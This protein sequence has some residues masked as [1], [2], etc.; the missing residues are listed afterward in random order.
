MQE[1]FDDPH[2]KAPLGSLDGVAQSIGDLCCAKE[3]DAD[4]N[5]HQRRCES[6][7]TT[8]HLVVELV[9]CPTF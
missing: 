3:G 7:S 8:S 6:T 9:N 4:R 1:V 5:A 2:V